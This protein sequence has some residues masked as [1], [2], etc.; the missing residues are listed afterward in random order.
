MFCVIFG[1]LYVQGFDCIQMFYKFRKFTEPFRI[2]AGALL[3]L[4]F[5]YQ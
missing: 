5:I 2:I 4:F 3:I 1:E